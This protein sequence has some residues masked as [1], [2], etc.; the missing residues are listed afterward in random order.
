MPYGDV[1]ARSR[2]IEGAA[3]ATFLSNPLATLPLGVSLRD[4]AALTLCHHPSD[5]LTASLLTAAEVGRG[6]RQHTGRH[7]LLLRNG[8]G[9]AGVQTLREVAGVRLGLSPDFDRSTPGHEVAAGEGTLFHRVGAALVQIDPDQLAALRRQ[10]G[11][12]LVSI[13]AERGFRISHAPKCSGVAPGRDGPV[14]GT[15]SEA[16]ATW[17]LETTGVTRSRFSGRGVRVAILD[18]GLDLEH[19][20]FAGRPVVSQSF[21]NGATVDDRHGHGTY[22]AGIACGPRSPA[23]APRYGIACDAALY[24]AKVIDDHGSGTDGSILAGMDW[25]VR[26]GCSIVSLSMGTPVGPGEPHSVV[27]EQVAQRAQAAGTLILAAAGNDSVRPDAIAP[28]DHPANCPSIWA[29]AAI[30]E[31]RRIAPFSCGGINANGGEVNIA[32]PGVAIRS[33]WCRPALYRN[34]SGTSM[35]T[36]CVAGIAA[37]LA[38]A[39]PQVRGRDLL[40]LLAKGA[41]PLPFPARDVGAGLIQT[42]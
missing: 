18:T 9:R 20:D 22:C 4:T 31:H 30:D 11:K 29:V 32:A 17:G 16:Q 28:G 34:D 25:A 33:A 13:E 27:Y 10:R 24:V 12:T 15:G 1:P 39:N 6:G 8:L 7:I 14:G 36:S 21:I 37:L 35:A 42:T 41:Q 19:P 23:Q 38:E 26:N 3:A 2:G 5:H 40:A